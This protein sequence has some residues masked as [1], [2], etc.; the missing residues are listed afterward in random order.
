[1]KKHRSKNAIAFEEKDDATPQKLK[2][3]TKDI[4]QNKL[5][6]VKKVLQPR[7]HF[8]FIFTKMERALC[9]GKY[10]RDV[11]YGS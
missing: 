3:L 10:F 9:R 6:Y 5:E 7:Y 8:A 1:M 4:L 2:S 11:I